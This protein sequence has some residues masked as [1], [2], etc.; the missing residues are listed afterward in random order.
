MK[1]A[2][3]KQTHKAQ[4]SRHQQFPFGLSLPMC[5]LNIIGLEAK[6]KLVKTLKSHKRFWICINLICSYMI[7]MG[8]VR[9]RVRGAYVYIQACYFQLACRSEHRVPQGAADQQKHC[10]CRFAINIVSILQ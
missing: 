2:N 9:G 7:S 3:D 6:L 4:E 8:P 10:R 1:A 5:R